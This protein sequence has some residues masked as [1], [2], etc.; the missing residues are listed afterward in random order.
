M[1]MFFVCKCI[2]R[3]CICVSVCLCASV[4]MCIRVYESVCFV[5]C[6]CA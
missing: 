1:N 2:C 5:V 6:K 3:L 4:C